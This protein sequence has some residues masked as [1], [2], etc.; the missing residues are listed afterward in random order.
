MSRHLMAK[1]RRA[2]THDLNPR[3]SSAF[4][5]GNSPRTVDL[6]KQVEDSTGVRLDN[7]YAGG[8][9]CYHTR[10]DDGSWMYVQDGDEPMNFEHTEDLSL[11]EAYEAEHGPL[12]WSV[13]FYPNKHSEEWGDYTEGPF[14]HLHIDKD[15]RTHDLPKVIQDALSTMPPGMENERGE[16]EGGVDYG[17][18]INGPGD[19]LNDDY[20]DFGGMFGGKP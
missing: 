15:A 5:K 14:H 4:G 19:D 17:K 6:L 7:A 20:G 12:G 3:T 16:S 8:T 13:A 18:L 1:M 9:G 11:R 2:T 10:L